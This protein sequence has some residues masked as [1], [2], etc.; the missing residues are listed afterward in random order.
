MWFPP[1]EDKEDE[2]LSAMEMEINRQMQCIRETKAPPPLGVKVVGKRAVGGFM[3][4][5]E[6]NELEVVRDDIDD[7]EEGDLDDDDD[8]GAADSGND[9]YYFEVRLSFTTCVY[10]KIQNLIY[11]P[12]LLIFHTQG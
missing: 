11:S 1:L 3:E 9:E 4:E 12:A 6:D 5:E 7:V 10:Y 8:G 2:H